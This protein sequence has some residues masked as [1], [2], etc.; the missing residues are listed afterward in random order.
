MGVIGG[1]FSTFFGEDFADFAHFSFNFL[2]SIETQ[3]EFYPF[4]LPFSFSP[5]FS[6]FL[7]SPPLI[8]FFFFFFHLLVVNL[9]N[10][11]DRN[12]PIHYFCRY[13]DEDK[14]GCIEIMIE[15]GFDVNAPNLSGETALH[16][17]AWK[18]RFNLCRILIRTLSI[19][20]FL[21][22]FSFFPLLSPSIFFFFPNLPYSFSLFPPP[23]PSSSILLPSFLSLFLDFSRVWRECQRP[24]G[25]Q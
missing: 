6:S 13:F 11:K 18:G 16:N 21:L 14:R 19:S 20:F 22:S 25:S 10:S 8:F 4:D 1:R 17:A 2:P 24:D 9:P 5:P 23:S 7:S 3:C 15:V 12:Y